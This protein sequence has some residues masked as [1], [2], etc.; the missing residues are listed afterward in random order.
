MKADLHHLDKWR[1]YDPPSPAGATYGAFTIPNPFD[2]GTTLCV[3]VSDGKKVQGTDG[4]EHVS[5][6]I[7]VAPKITRIPNW[8]EMDWI[9]ELFW[10]MNEIVIQFHINDA[11]KINHHKTTLHLWK[12]PYPII[13]PP[14]VL[15]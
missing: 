10:D 3:I 5:V 14:P 12:P 13:L 9:K 7:G 2:R 6:H 1:V 11:R 15:I 8:R 4:W